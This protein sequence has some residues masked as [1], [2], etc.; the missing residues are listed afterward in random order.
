MNQMSGTVECEAI[1]ME[2]TAQTSDGSFLLKDNRIV[3]R[4]MIS[5]AHS[6]E[7]AADNNNPIHERMSTF[8]RRYAER[9]AAD[10]VPHSVATAQA[11][12]IWLNRSATPLRSAPMM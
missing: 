5:G 11:I 10:S 12:V 4:Q 1:L 6:G 2:R 8:I 9:P 7:T 3:L